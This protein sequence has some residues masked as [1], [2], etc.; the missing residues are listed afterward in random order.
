MT[1]AN[2]KTYYK[3]RNSF[4]TTK[5]CFSNGVSVPEKVFGPKPS[6][7]NQT[8]STPADPEIFFKRTFQANKF[9]DD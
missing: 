8:M 6:P 3:M 5:K 1:L 2:F 4:K 7:K 9:C